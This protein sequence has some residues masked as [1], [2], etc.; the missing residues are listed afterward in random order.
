MPTNNFILFSTKSPGNLNAYILTVFRVQNIHSCSD[1]L[2]DLQKKIRSPEGWDNEKNEEIWGGEAIE[3]CQLVCFFLG[4]F[5]A[6]VLIP[7]ERPN[8]SL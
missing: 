7:A 6:G 2:K 8:C 1:T 5:S 3:L 4:Y